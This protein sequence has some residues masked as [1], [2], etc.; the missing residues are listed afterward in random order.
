M[1]TR[2]QR[3]SVGENAIGSIQWLI[4]ENPPIDAKISQI[5]R[6]QTEICPKFCSMATGV[7]RKNSL[8][9]SMAHPRNPTLYRRK[10][11]ADIFYTSQVI[12]NFVPN[13]VGM[14]TGVNQGKM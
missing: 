3:G 1:A 10:N 5:S 6:T 2:G 14:A 4:T 7:D 11:L 12:A 13:F 8:Q 9:H